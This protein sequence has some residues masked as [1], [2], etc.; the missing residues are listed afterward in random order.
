MD[1]H[2]K[3]M[4]VHESMN[5]GH[6]FSHQQQAEKH[7]QQIPAQDNSCT[8]LDTPAIQALKKLEDIVKQSITSTD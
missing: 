2:E 1:K 6:A 4:V 5:N 3:A 7:R 8:I